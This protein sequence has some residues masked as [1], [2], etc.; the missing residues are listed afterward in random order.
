MGTIL[1]KCL[2]WSWVGAGWGGGG[3]PG[4][5]DRLEEKKKIHSNTPK[6]RRKEDLRYWLLEQHWLR[7]SRLA[8]QTPK[9]AF[10]HGLKTEPRIQHTSSHRVG[11][12]PSC[13]LRRVNRKL[14]RGAGRL[15]LV[16]GSAYI[17]T[18]SDGRRSRGRRRVPGLGSTEN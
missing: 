17:P 10:G 7:G 2:L 1:F 9:V 14:A 6:I 4:R 18:V 13:V 11:A 5:D 12:G 8:R 3:D 15:G 16:L